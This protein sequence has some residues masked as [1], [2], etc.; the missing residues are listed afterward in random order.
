MKRAS[1]R[2]VGHSLRLRSGQALSD[3][4]VLCFIDDGWD[5]IVSR[6][7]DGLRGTR[8]GSESPLLL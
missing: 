1:S 8:S 5:E 3:A 6:G 4:F 2:Q 7:R